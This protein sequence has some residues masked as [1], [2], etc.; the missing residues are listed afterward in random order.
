LSIHIIIDGYNMIRRSRVLGEGAGDIQE[1]RERLIDFLSRYRK[2]R[3]HDVTVVFDGADAPSF[4]PRRDHVRG[5][6]VV[7]S[8][9]GESADSVIMRMSSAEQE[10]AL[11]VSS[12]RAVAD[13]AASK[14]SAT[15]E[16]HRFEARVARVLS[17]GPGDE[18]D[19]AGRT[20]ARGLTRKKGPGRRLSKRNRRSRIKIRKI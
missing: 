6:G 14:G 2:I 15:I 3:S 11:V 8:R 7:F 1:E 10:R 16:S 5:V 9:R 17:D 19:G 20:P 12:D 4:M 13:F 18:D